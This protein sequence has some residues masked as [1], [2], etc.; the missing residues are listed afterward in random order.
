MDD[1]HITCTGRIQ[2]VK[3]SKRGMNGV[4]SKDR[5]QE[6][7]VAR[8]V[9]ERTAYPV[10]RRMLG[11]FTEQCPNCGRGRADWEFDFT[12]GPPIREGDGYDLVAY[13][14]ACGTRFRKVEDK[15]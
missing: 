3:T 13:V 15:S 4:A 11:A 1:Q 5:S 2:Y 10:V 8:K 7:E 14:C 9:A 6:L 12:S